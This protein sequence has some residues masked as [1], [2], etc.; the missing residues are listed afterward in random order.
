MREKMSEDDYDDIR[1]EVWIDGQRHMLTP[2]QARGVWSDQRY[3]EEQLARRPDERA[4]GRT[5]HRRAWDAI[6]K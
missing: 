1:V 3:A 6:K 5:D 4:A 2:D